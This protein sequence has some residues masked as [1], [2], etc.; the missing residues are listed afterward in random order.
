MQK[1][2]SCQCSRFLFRGMVV[3]FLCTIILSGL[4]L[5]TPFAF[6]IAHAAGGQASFALQ[7]VTYDPS[8]PLT[9]AYFIFNSKSGVVIR[10]RVRVI[11]SG[12]ATGKVSLYPVDA[13]TGQTSG[14]VYLNQTDPRN[15]VGAWISLGKAQLT[16]GPGQSQIVT[17]TITI[18]GQ[19]RVG[20][21]LGGIVAENL[22]QPSTTPTTNPGSNTGTF[23]ISVKNLTIIAVQVNVPGATNSILKATGFQAG[24]QNGYQQLL[25]GLS[26]TGTVMLKPYGTLQV[27]D[28]QDHIVE[29]SSL[30]LDTFLPQTSINYPITITGPALGTGTYTAKLTLMYGSGQT[31]NY[32]KTFSIT[33]QQLAQVFS[34]SKTQVPG[35]FGGN[36]FS[37][38]PWL[39]LIGVLVIV[40]V[41]G[42]IFFWRLMLARGKAKNNN[43]FMKTKHGKYSSQFK[44]PGKF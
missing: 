21:H 3:S 9:R 16:L 43:L 17:F 39:L 38:F 23:H 13:T 18:P 10:N 25:V 32:K 27:T 4:F 19:A 31:L 20:Q 6:L 42:N 1:L 29:N 33:Q 15:D 37:L 30:K 11:N 8:N 28:A 34:S 36:T 12:T 26:N 5:I 41:A 40:L 44:K 2:F 22:T 35:S 24:G 7:P 14:A